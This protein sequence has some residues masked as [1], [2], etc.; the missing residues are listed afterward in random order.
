MRPLEPGCPY[1]RQ[2]GGD[3]NF[4]ANFG[5]AIVYTRARQ[6]YI[7]ACSNVG[8][9]LQNLSFSLDI[10]NSM[11]RYMRD[12]G[13]QPDSAAAQLLQENPDL[14]D[15]WLDGVTTLDGKDGDGKDGAA[16]VKASLG[17]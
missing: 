1:R 17:M 15:R 16:A 12:H 10:E 11:M 14:I 7:G 3:D 13:M 5:G 8:K 6:G 2:A 9:L 4:S